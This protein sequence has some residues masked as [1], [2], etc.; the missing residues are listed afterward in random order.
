MRN[1]IH[2]G[3]RLAW[4]I[5]AWQF[6][7]AVATA[8]A[9]LIAGRREALAALLGGCLVAL[10]SV[11]FALRY[12][13]RRQPDASE[14]LMR[15]IVSTVVKWLVVIGGLIVLLGQWNMAPL[16]LVTGLAVALMVNVA[17]LRFQ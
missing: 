16:P 7:A 9:W 8:V 11:V 6:A 4:R 5:A 12:F 13:G 10:G 17:G 14:V 1:S 15:L 3:R 2:Q